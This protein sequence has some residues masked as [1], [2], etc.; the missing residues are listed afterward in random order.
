MKLFLLSRNRPLFLWAC[1]DSLYRLTRSPV[2]ITVI[3]AA[4][5]DPLVGE[6]LD[7]FDRRGLFERI[8]RLD[9]ND[10]GRVWATIAGL[11]DAE[12]EVI[13]YIES[14]VVIEA[15]PYPCWLARMETLLRADKGLA[16]LGSAIVKDDFVSLETAR[17]LLPG[18]DETVLRE[19]IYA[20]DPEC[21]QDVAEA[22]GEPVFSPHN[23]AGRLLLLRSAALREFGPATDSDMHERLLEL[24]WTSGISTEIRHRHLSLLNIFDYPGYDVRKRNAYMASLSYKAQAERALAGRALSDDPDL[25]VVADAMRIDPRRD[26]DRLVFDLPDGVATIRLVSRRGHAFGTDDL[27][28]LGVALDTL[29]LDGR[30]AIADP[31][32]GSGWYAFEAEGSRSRWMNGAAGLPP[33]REVVLRISA[34]VPYLPEQ[35]RQAMVAAAIVPPQ[36]L[37]GTPPV[38]PPAPG[39]AE[40]PIGALDFATWETCWGWAWDPQAPDA[41]VDLDIRLDGEKLFTLPAALYR[42]DLVGAGIGNGRHGFYFRVPDTL[43]ARSAAVLEIT[44]A[45]SGRH[46]LGSPTLLRGASAEAVVPLDAALGEVTGRLLAHAGHPDE[47]QALATALLCQFDRVQQHL[48]GLREARTGRDLRL[49]RLGGLSEAIGQ[50]VQAVIERYPVLRI[51]PVAAPEL[52]VIVPVHGRFDLA[53]RAIETVIAQSGPDAFA[54]PGGVEIIL[55]DDGSRDE[56]MFAALV[57]DGVTILRHAQAQGFVG[58]VTAGVGAARG[59]MLLL[60]NS[61]TELQPQ[62]LTEMRRTF[63]LDPAIGIVGARLLAP[64]GRIGEVGGIVWRLGDAWNWG[65]GDDPD[66]PGLRHLR[67]ADYVSGAA[68][69]IGRELFD[70]VGGLSAEF[71]PG[72]YEDTDLCFKVRAAGR[73]VVVQ[74]AASVLHHEGASAGT[75]VEGDG[76]KRFQ[77]INHRRFLDKWRDVLAGHALTAHDPQ[78]EAE[79]GVTRRALFIDDR[80]P[81]PDQDAGSVAAVAHM[82]SLQRLGYGVTQIGAEMDRLDPYTADLERIGIRCLYAPFVATVEQAIRSSETVYDLVYLHRLGNASAYLP[83]VRA[84]FPAARIVYGLADL[85]ALRAEREHALGLGEGTPRSLDALRRLER[86]TIAAADHVIT[87][88]THE[89]A[90]ISAQTEVPVSV[91]AWPVRRVADVPTWRGRSGLVFVGGYRH[92]PNVDASMVAGRGH[93]APGVAGA[94]GDHPRPD[95]LAS[96]GRVAATGRGGGAGARACRRSRRGAVGGAAECRVAALRCGREGQGAEQ[97]RLRHPVRD[98]ADRRR[99]ARPAAGA[100]RAG[101]CDRRG[102]RRAHPRPLRR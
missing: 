86:A 51:A 67:D 6:V 57:L 89:A 79:R 90:L 98:D 34:T 63:D 80:I 95:R 26:G 5:D 59:R 11:V 82:R 15:G 91:V 31:G 55:V 4:S 29:R 69:M 20:G 72:Y 22:D 35:D 54:W 16:M 66:A 13:G 85:H 24:G 48:L 23:P 10:P 44:L 36:S 97:P 65:R 33:C 52:S 42:S 77:K 50:T 38:S 7:G 93:H 37:P 101:R 30:E 14:D 73:R 1:L 8:I 32:L 76:M 74:P 68:L 88:S 62:A 81:T 102:D 61:D 83:M 60:L 45:S 84:R 100:D 87:H 25:H 47:V 75:D 46:I 19:L 70:A 2:A 40:V 41:P 39:P 21:R 9:S 17:R 96:A 58:A 27:R 18:A 94:P 71:A 28:P 43:A 99:G 49:D 64:D 3:D 78:A 53:Y 12:D 56:T 92:P